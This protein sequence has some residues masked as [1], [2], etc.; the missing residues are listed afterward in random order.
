M[1]FFTLP[2]AIACPSLLQYYNLKDIAFDAR[3]L[4]TFMLAFVHIILHFQLIRKQMLHYISEMWSVFMSVNF[5]MNTIPFV[6]IIRVDEMLR[7]LTHM[8][9]QWWVDIETITWVTECYIYHLFF[10]LRFKS[11]LFSR[12]M[13]FIH[14]FGD[15]I[16]L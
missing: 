12:Y 4:S 7:T 5:V 14:W 16:F 11:S 13:E 9:I 1:I 6:E 2:E 10:V 15:V 3:W 8:H